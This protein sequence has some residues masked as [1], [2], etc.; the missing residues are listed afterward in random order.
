ML[1]RWRTP[2]TQR[3]TRFRYTSRDDF[4]VHA[5]AATIEMRVHLPVG[6]PA[7]SSA[8]VATVA[9]SAA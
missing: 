5:V 4:T 6:V 3:K 1:L 2:S 9:V 7:T 8:A